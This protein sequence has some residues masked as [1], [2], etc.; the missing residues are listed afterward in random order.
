MNRVNGQ[1]EVDKGRRVWELLARAC[2]EYAAEVW[3]TAG[4]SAF[5]K[6][7]SS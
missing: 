6:F 4:H 5:K 2:M 1:V 7:E 3:W